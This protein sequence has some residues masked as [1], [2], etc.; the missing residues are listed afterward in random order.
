MTVPALTYC[1]SMSSE[2]A[3]TG[4]AS[5]MH[6]ISNFDKFCLSFFLFYHFGAWILYFTYGNLSYLVGK[7]AT[8][9]KSALP[10]LLSVHMKRSQFNCS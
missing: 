1:V 8:K 9:Y 5:F 4:C 10:S 7:V 6:L 2:S 3:A